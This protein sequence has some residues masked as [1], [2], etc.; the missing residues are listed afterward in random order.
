MCIFWAGRTG[1]FSWSSFVNDVLKP[2]EAMRE[3][4][5]LHAQVIQASDRGF[6]MLGAFQLWMYAN[7]AIS[8]AVLIEGNIEPWWMVFVNA[9]V[10][11]S[12]AVLFRYSTFLKGQVIA[13][14]AERL[15]V[16]EGFMM[17]VAVA[18]G[19]S[20]IELQRYMPSPGQPVF[21]SHVYLM[22]WDTHQKR[23]E[24]QQ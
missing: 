2:D 5:R 8:A 7:A 21:F 24:G 23:K 12:S 22:V 16:S 11:I 9:F 14:Q 3:Y 6:R 15:E 1:P 10:V 20:P 19:L 4:V 18:L 13:R 17:D